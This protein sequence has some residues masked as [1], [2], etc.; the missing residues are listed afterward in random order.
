VKKRPDTKFSPA[1]V[2]LSASALACSMQT[3]PV[4]NLQLSEFWDLCCALLL[5]AARGEPRAPRPQTPLNH[6]AC[7]DNMIRQQAH[8]LQTAQHGSAAAG[9]QE[10]RATFRLTV[11]SSCPKPPYWLTKKVALGVSCR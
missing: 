8:A 7:W 4:I 11:M 3:A 2:S 5:P 9:S 10:G 6:A 1:L